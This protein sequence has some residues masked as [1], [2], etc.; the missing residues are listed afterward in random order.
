[1]IFFSSYGISAK[2]AYTKFSEK[3]S[4]SELN[5]EKYVNDLE[6]A[7]IDD[8]E[9]LQF[10]KKNYP[11]AVMSGSGSTYYAINQQLAPQKDYRVENDLVA[12]PFGVQ[13]LEN[14]PSGS[15]K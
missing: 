5:R 2:E 9:E 6:W 1:M 8:Y 10:I 4:R 13:I 3:K 7:I 11:D 14:E 15:L 12:I